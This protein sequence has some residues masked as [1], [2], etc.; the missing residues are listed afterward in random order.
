MAMNR[1]ARRAA[2]ARNS[3]RTSF[4]TFITPPRMRRGLLLGASGL[5]LAI[6]LG[7][8]KDAVAHDECGAAAGAPP[9]V[10]CT[11]AG[12]PY[13]GGIF[14]EV[15]DLTIVVKSGVIINTTTKLDEPGGVVSG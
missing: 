6:G 2:A 7:T 9:S 3:V 5:T 14:Y 11:P 10:T 12:N 13:A 15:D 4:F 1:R 8:A